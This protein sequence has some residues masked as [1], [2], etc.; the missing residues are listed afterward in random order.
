[1]MGRAWR[2]YRLERR[3]FWRNPS[4]AFFN[5]AGLHSF[6]DKWQPRWE[7]RYLVYRSD[8]DLPKAAIG[9]QD[10]RWGA[11]GIWVL[12]NPSGLNAHWSRAAMAAEFGRLRAAAQL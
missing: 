4:A 9:R 12:P 11:T 10:E 1:M 8:A 5:F 3:T 7:P 6:K 2:Q